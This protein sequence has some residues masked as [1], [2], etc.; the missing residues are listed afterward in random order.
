M[1]INASH[2]GSNKVSAHVPKSRAQVADQ[3][4]KDLM[5]PI[6]TRDALR[7]VNANESVFDSVE[8]LP[9]RGQSIFVQHARDGTSERDSTLKRVNSIIKEQGRRFR[10]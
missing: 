9:K 4:Y 3:A 2:G 1:Q 7:A 6:N 10:S 5:R 8:L